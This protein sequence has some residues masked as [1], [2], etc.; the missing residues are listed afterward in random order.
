MILKDAL[1]NCILNYKINRYT[2]TDG[3]CK[4]N[5]DTIH[6]GKVLYVV[7]AFN[8]VTLIKYQHRLLK[9]FQEMNFLLGS[10]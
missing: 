9:R 5:M 4:V 8:D 3:Q 1:Y 7:I 10:R 2:R 6:N